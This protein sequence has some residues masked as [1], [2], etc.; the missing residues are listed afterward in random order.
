MSPSLS[1]KFQ[2]EKGLWQWLTDSSKPRGRRKKKGNFGHGKSVPFPAALRTC[3][4]E[5]TKKEHCYHFIGTVTL[6]VDFCIA[7]RETKEEEKDQHPHQQK[8]KTCIWNFKGKKESTEP[9]P[10][11]RRRKKKKKAIVHSQ[12]SIR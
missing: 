7:C 8:R 12:R 4:E 2:K 1:P 3:W 6:R 10:I 11:Q 9:N 5:E